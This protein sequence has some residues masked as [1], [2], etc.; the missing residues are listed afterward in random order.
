[1]A[2]IIIKSE[3]RRAREEKVLRDF[4][5]DPSRADAQNREYAEEI[6]SR[7]TEALKEME[8]HENEYR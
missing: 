3:E 1:M 4:G 7:T 2:H 6:A 8:A 5:H